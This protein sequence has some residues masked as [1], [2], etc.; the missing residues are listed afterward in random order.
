MGPRRE[1]SERVNTDAAAAWL[2]SAGLGKGAICRLMVLIRSGWPIRHPSHSDWAPLDHICVQLQPF[3]RHEAVLIRVCH[4]LFLVL[5][6]LQK[7][8]F[9]SLFGSTVRSCFWAGLKSD[10]AHL[11]FNVC[12]HWLFFGLCHFLQRPFGESEKW[13]E[14]KH[15][16]T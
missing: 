15:K 7:H 9:S 3:V 8:I 14:R 12:S 6:L 11:F 13:N 4:F 16:H 10:R 1:N 2:S 5:N